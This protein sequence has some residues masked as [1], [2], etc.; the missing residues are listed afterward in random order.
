MISAN[1]E[2]TKSEEQIPECDWFTENFYTRPSKIKF[3]GKGSFGKVFHVI[4]REDKSH[5]ALKIQIFTSESEYKDSKQEIKLTKKLNHKNIIK[6]EDYHCEKL[7]NGVY[8]IYIVLELA[9]GS[10]QAEISKGILRDQISYYNSINQLVQAIKYCH[11]KNIV[12]FDLKPDN[13]LIFADDLLKVADWGAAKPGLSKGTLTFKDYNL[14]CTKVFA[15]PELLEIIEQNV[16]NFENLQKNWQKMDVYA[17]GVTLLS[18]LGL[19]QQKIVNIKSKH[20]KKYDDLLEVN[21]KELITQRNFQQEWIDLFKYMLAYEPQNRFTIDK[22]AEYLKSMSFINNQMDLVRH[23]MSTTGTL[24]L[25]FVLDTT[26]TMDYYMEAVLKSLNNILINM[27]QST[28][29]RKINIGCLFYKDLKGKPVKLN[30]DEVIPKELL[31]EKMKE[32]EDPRFLTFL[33]GLEIY[34]DYI[35]Y[36]QFTPSIE[37]IEKKLKELKY[38]CFG[39]DDYCEDLVE[40]LKASMEMNW[41]YQSTFRIMVII[42]DAPP[43]G[44]SYYELAYDNYPEKDKQFDNLEETVRRL[45]KM[46]I[47]IL[48]IEIDKRTKRMNEI[49]E[50][51]CKKENGFFQKVV[52][53]EMKDPEYMKQ[54]F[55]TE[56]INEIDS[57]FKDQWNIFLEK[58]IKDNINWEMQIDWEKEFD[59]ESIKEIKF[60]VY[61]FEL[62][63]DSLDF[64]NLSLLRMENDRSSKW[65]ASV[66]KKRVLEGNLRNIHLMLTHKS[67]SKYVIKL[68]KDGS[69][70]MIEELM[71]DWKNY[72]VSYFVASKFKKELKI[73]GINLMKNLDF[74]NLII[75]ES[76]DPFKGSR[77]FACEKFLDGIFLK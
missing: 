72:T 15:S 12:H 54:F 41:T 3:L 35:N 28:N 51:I 8:A 77:F 49:I 69:Y 21:L 68:P 23:L 58:K 53:E 65:N 55:E 38:C 27:K 26:G 32:E 56:V 42:T 9:Q 43:H 22:V 66:S 17:L 34:N 20:G 74:L 36:L 76:E 44:K 71:D 63:K 2:P 4:S 37:I 40:A 64:N 24:D 18:F 6:I 14:G 60:Q 30:S 31:K 13:I 59:P 52:L 16:E 67:Q 29:K 11:E 62:V 50:K 45:V 7:A 39:G 48:I 19:S 33:K 61:D 5:K 57:I 46:K 75:L 73:K 47:G 70:N 1:K 25:L 10:L